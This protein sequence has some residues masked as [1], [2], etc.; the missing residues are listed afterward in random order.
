[1]MGRGHAKERVFYRESIEVLDDHVLEVCEWSEGT[2]ES[3]GTKD[4]FFA[5]RVCIHICSTDQ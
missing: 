1:M 2:R 4:Q 3:L 5:T